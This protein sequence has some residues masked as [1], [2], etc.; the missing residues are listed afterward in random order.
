MSSPISGP[1]SGP[2][3]VPFAKAVSPKGKVYAVDVD[4]NF[5]PYIEK[6]VKAAGVSNVQTVLGVFTD[7]KFPPLMS[8]SRFST[9]CCITSRIARATSRLQRRTLEPGARIA[10]IDYHSAQSP[11]QYQPN[12]I[13]SKE[14]AARWLADAGLKPA[15]D[16]TLFTEKW[17]LVYAKGR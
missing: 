6:R 2:F 7:P 1:E 13:V 10:I 4:R 9:T 16:I 5:F 14:Q 15:E 3:V 17:F 8:I 12:L 11:H